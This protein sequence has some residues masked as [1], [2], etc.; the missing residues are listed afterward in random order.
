LDKLLAIKAEFCPTNN[1]CSW[2]NKTKQDITDAI[3]SLVTALS[4]FEV[5]DGNHLKTNKG[6]SFYDK[7]TS[8]VNDIFIPEQS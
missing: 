8:T 2:D 7:V 4:Y 6:L 1:N 3:S 5:N